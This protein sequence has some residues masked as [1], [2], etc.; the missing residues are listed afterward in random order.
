MVGSI[1]ALRLCLLRL[2][3]VMFG[4]GLGVCKVGLVYCFWAPVASVG[5]T[6]KSAFLRTIEKHIYKL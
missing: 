1:A 5:I 2:D 4:F 3:L 6:G